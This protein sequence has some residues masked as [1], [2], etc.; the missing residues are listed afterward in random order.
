MNGFQVRIKLGHHQPLV[1]PAEFLV[2]ILLLVGL[3]EERVDLIDYVNVLEVDQAENCDLKEGDCHVLLGLV[4]V[5]L[6]FFLHVFDLFY[7]L[8]ENKVLAIIRSL[9]YLAELFYEVRE[10]DFI[11]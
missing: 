5:R 11:D 2:C 6:A 9:D 8:F 7:G 3:L 10:I 4:V 1:V